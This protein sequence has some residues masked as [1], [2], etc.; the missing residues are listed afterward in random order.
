M[1]MGGVPPVTEEFHNE[2]DDDKS[3]SPS[4]LSSVV[5][6]DGIHDVEGFIVVCFVILIGDMSRGVMFP[7]LWPLVESLGGSKVTQGI[8]VAAFSGGR[9]LVNPMFGSWSISMGYTRTLLVSVSILLVGT[10][11]YAQIEN[12]GKLQFLVLSQLILGIGSGTLGVTRAFVADV[13]AQRNRTTYMAWITAVQYGGFTVTPFIGALFSNLLADKDYSFGCVL[14][15]WIVVTMNDEE[16]LS[17]SPSLSWVLV[18]TVLRCS[19]IELYPIYHSQVDFLL[20]S[21]IFPASHS[22]SPRVFGVSSP[23]RPP[24]PPAIE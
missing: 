17:V 8:A 18:S 19:V 5:S 3:L 22:L 9:I 13:T 4:I 2:H 7:T 15:E 1:E 6:A 16:H 10:L 11:V 23:A 12:V 21:L 24:L 20:L 14:H